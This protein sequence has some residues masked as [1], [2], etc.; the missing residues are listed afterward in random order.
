MNSYISKSKD[1]PIQ[2]K[3][4]LHFVRFWKGQDVAAHLP[5]Y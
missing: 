3:K 1:L 5:R 2:E 4:F